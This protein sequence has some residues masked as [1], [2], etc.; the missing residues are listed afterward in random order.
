MRFIVAPNMIGLPALSLPVGL[1]PAE[2]DRT[3]GACG[4]GLLVCVAQRVREC[5]C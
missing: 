1:V 5:L 2:E 3:A 4:A